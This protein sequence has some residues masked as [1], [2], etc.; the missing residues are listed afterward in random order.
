MDSRIAHVYNE[1]AFRYL[2]GL[3]RSRA[4]RSDH[5]C[6]L[7]LVDCG[8]ELASPAPIDPLLARRLFAGLCGALRETDLIGW[9]REH[10]IAGAL[11]PSQSEQAEE[12]SGAVSRRIARTLSESMP[13]EPGSRLQVRICRVPPPL[14]I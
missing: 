4:G 11:L 8:G 14:S 13:A 12:V 1:E 2:L 7:V 6:L 9:Y 10:R 3:Q 5:P